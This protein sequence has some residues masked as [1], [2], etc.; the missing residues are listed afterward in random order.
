[1]DDGETRA[2]SSRQGQKS[3]GTICL[4]YQ[5]DGRDRKPRGIWIDGE[6]AT[7]RP[8]MAAVKPPIEFA[9]NTQR[10]STQQGN[11]RNFKEREVRY[12]VMEC[13]EE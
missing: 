9:M 11:L 6:V 10:L 7:W 1:M 4:I 2:E 3:V 8:D 5:E 13:R 12:G